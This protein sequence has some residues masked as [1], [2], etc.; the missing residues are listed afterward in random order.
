MGIMPRKWRTSIPVPRFLKGLNAIQ[1]FR[2]GRVHIKYVFNINELEK[3]ASQKLL[4]RLSGRHLRP[5]PLTSEQIA[6][7]Y[8]RIKHW[9]E[10]PGKGGKI[11][12]KPSRTPFPVYEFRNGKLRPIRSNYY[13][14]EIRKRAAEQ[15]KGNVM[16]LEQIIIEKERLVTELEKKKPGSAKKTTR[17]YALLSHNRKL[18]EL[19]AT[20]V[21]ACQM[22]LLRMDVL[23]KY[24]ET[25]AIGEHERMKQLD[26]IRDITT[27]IEVR[28]G[29]A[30]KEK[31]LAENRINLLNEFPGIASRDRRVIERL[32]QELRRKGTARDLVE[33]KW[34]ETR[35]RIGGS[36]PGIEFA[37]AKA[38]LQYWKAFNTLCAAY[39]KAFHTYGTTLSKI[40]EQDIRNVL[41]ENKDRIQYFSRYVESFQPPPG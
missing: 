24:I 41:R 27:A 37:R 25:T 19:Y 10:E 18:Q 30:E 33:E 36:N 38:Q 2:H 16:A 6:N 21:S 17:R 5:I 39:M 15:G 34:L 12:Y 4:Y 26:A 7:W 28:K 23:K 40:E 20:I 29:N 8:L 13:Y 14:L 32:A 31:F 9:S 35:G 3:K 1:L 22:Q 11:V